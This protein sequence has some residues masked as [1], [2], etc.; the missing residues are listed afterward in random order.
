MNP[1]VEL[2]ERLV[3]ISIAGTELINEDFRLKKTLET[4][5]G[6][7][8]KNPVFKK[9]YSELKTLFDAENDK[10]PTQL[11]NLLGLVDAVLYTQ[12]KTDIE[13]ECEKI[14]LKAINEITKQYKYSEI[15]HILNALTTTGSGRCEVLQTAIIK[16]PEFFKD[17]R[18]INALIND[19]DD[20]YGE[21]SSYVSDCILSIGTGEACE[22]IDPEDYEL[23]SYVLPMANK[24]YIIS[25]LKKGFDPEG[26]KLME[27]R[28]LLISKIAKEQENDFYI[29]VLQ[30]A[31]KEM[32]LIAI[33]A[34]G[35]DEKNIPLLLELAKTEKGNA[36]EKVYDVLGTFEFDGM[37]DFWKQELKRSASVAMCITSLKSDDISDLLAEHIKEGLEKLLSNTKAKKQNFPMMLNHTY[38]KTSDKMLELYKWILDSKDDFAKAECGE[39]YYTECVIAINSAISRAV[40]EDC[41]QKLIDFLNNQLKDYKQQLKTPMFL[42]NVLTLPADKAYEKTI[43]ANTVKDM[44]Y[45]ANLFKGIIEYKDNKYYAIFPGA[46]REL[47]EPLDQR[48]FED[49]MKCDF[50]QLIQNLAPKEPYELCQKIGKY[51]YQKILNMSYIQNGRYTSNIDYEFTNNAMLFL[52]MMEYCGYSECDYAMLSVCKNKPDISVW[53]ITWLFSRFA[54]CAGEERTEKEAQRVLEFYQKEYKDDEKFEKIKQAFIEN[55]YIKCDYSI[56]SVCKNKP[57]IPAWEIAWL[58]SKFANHLGEERIQQEAQRVLVFYQREHKD[59]EKFEKIKQ[60]FIQN[61][62]IKG[63]V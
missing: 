18:I 44:K 37:L 57:D 23:K 56:L 8:D 19:L 35:Y 53:N 2:K 26:K 33:S 61:G 63:E 29:S 27:K 55:G 59:D 25:R 49:L 36:R 52:R 31:K 40:V 28:L 39:S 48:W 20:P 7:A 16:T 17:Y 42:A 47:K 22:V 46:K 14:E 9:I 5:E 45:F 43:D 4:F 60:A 30:K 3:N 15:S 21:L 41:S 34:L 62:Y 12:A 32:R 24:D 10:K 54:S 1:L 13:G 11:L 58:F 38:G 6:L 50:Y 51:F